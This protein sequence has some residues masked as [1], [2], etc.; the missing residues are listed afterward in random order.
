METSLTQAM[1]VGHL[2]RAADG[3]TAVARALGLRQSAVSNWITR[4]QVPLE[5]AAAVCALAGVDPAK[6]RPDV[7]WERDADGR[8]VSYRVP[9]SM[10]A[11]V[12]PDPSTV[13]TANAGAV[14]G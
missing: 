4:G 7:E 1:D 11:T 14:E 12:D 3:P 5:H 6:V 8:V 13:E 10:V 9:V 2:I